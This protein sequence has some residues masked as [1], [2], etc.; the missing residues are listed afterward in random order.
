MLKISST[1]FELKRKSGGSRKNKAFLG[2]ISEHL[3]FSSKG[4]SRFF[5]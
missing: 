3:I 1:I 5:F 4:F 2:Q